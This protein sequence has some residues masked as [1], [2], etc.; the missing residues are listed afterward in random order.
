MHDFIPKYWKIDIIY[1]FRKYVVNIN[2]RIIR[3]SKES[4][5]YRRIENIL[6]QSLRVWWKKV[7]QLFKE[8]IMYMLD[9][10]FPNHEYK[11]SLL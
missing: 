10:Q 5:H 11:I 2:S 6:Y 1:T 4:N 9:I 7:Q 3:E 8:K